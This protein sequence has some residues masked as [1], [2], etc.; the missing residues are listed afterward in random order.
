MFRRI[1]QSA[2][3]MVVRRCFAARQIPLYHIFSKNTR[4]L[5][6]QAG[7]IRAVSVSLLYDVGM[8]AQKMPAQLY[9]V[10]FFCPLAAVASSFTSH[11]L[12]LRTLASESVSQVLNHVAQPVNDPQQP[13]RFRLQVVEPR[14]CLSTSARE[15]HMRTARWW[16]F[17]GWAVSRCLVG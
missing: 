16:C 2:E 14:W 3:S 5:S 11:S 6:T 8:P 4:R 13:L 17:T 1:K 12:S 15:H 7:A 10:A 9:H